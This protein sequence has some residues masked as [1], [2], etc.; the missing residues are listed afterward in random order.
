MLSMILPLLVSLHSGHGGK[1]AKDLPSSTPVVPIKSAAAARSD[2]SSLSRAIRRRSCSVRVSI[3]SLS[4]PC[5]QPPTSKTDMF[6]SATV[7]RVDAFRPR[8]QRL[9][10]LTHLLS[11]QLLLLGQFLLQSQ[12]LLDGRGGSRSGSLLWFLRIRHI[13]IVLQVSLILLVSVPASSKMEGRKG[14]THLLGI[15]FILILPF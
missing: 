1:E 14:G 3:T 4:S 8:G 6:L 7:C 10:A 2:S 15:L 13:P 5:R 11:S 9:N 12:L